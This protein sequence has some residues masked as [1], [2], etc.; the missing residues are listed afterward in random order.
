MK[1]LTPT[2]LTLTVLLM[3]TTHAENLS[4][5][6]ITPGV[7]MAP[8]SANLTELRSVKSSANGYSSSVHSD[9]RRAEDLRAWKRSVVGVVGSQ[10]LD[11]ISSYGMIERNPLLASTN[12]G[13][14]AKAASIKFGT[15]AAVVGIEY[16]LVKKYPSAARLISKLNW[17]SSVL[18]SG[19]AV[20]NFAIK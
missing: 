10:S 13:F 4:P 17:S 16:F 7:V 12:G 6:M 9:M 1:H 5:A 18:T 8:V 19:L 15:T 3:S 11:V 20:H 14:G 2:I